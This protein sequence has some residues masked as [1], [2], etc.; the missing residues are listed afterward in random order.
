MQRVGL[1]LLHSHTSDPIKPFI[2]TVWRGSLSPLSKGC[3][4][5]NTF[6][7]LVLEKF[8]SFFQNQ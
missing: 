2:W 8:C 6:P 1:R 3:P 7:L 5:Q 4:A